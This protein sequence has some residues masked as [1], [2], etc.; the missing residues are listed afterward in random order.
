VPAVIAPQ[1]PSAPLPFF[2]AVQAWQ[3]PVQAVLQQTPST[4]LPL[5]HWLPCEHAWPVVSTQAPAPL[6]VLVPVQLGASGWP[7]GTLVQVPRLPGTLHAWQVPLQPELQQTP[8]TQ[9]P[10]A[11]WLSCEQLWPAER[12]QAPAPLQVSGAVQGV[13]ATRSGWPAGRK[14]QVPTLPVRL[15]DMQVPLQL[16]LQQTPSTQLPERHWLLSEQAWPLPS[17]HPPAPLQAL[18]ATQVLDG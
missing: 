7:D 6:Q 13:V 14:A 16:V 5:R 18:G 11:H 3:L 12:R 10:L 17:T 4:Q 1:V 8:S 9:L 15:Q 2:V